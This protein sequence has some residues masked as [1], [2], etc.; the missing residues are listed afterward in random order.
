MA[1]SSNCSF[2]RQEFVKLDVGG[3]SF[4]MLKSTVMKYPESLLA[5]MVDEFPGLVNSG[6]PLYIDRNPK[7]FK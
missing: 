1:K 5:K 7:T 4:K 3:T 6:D 2:K